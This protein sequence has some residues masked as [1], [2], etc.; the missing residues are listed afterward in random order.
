MA[1]AS[2]RWIRPGRWGLRELREIRVRLEHLVHPVHLARR[3]PLAIQG[4]WVMRAPQVLQGL[5]VLRDPLARAMCR[6]SGVP[7]MMQSAELLVP[8]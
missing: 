3:G 7:E 1:V 4:P 8:L 2:C 6:S 5:L